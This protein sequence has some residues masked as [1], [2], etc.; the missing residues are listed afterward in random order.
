[1]YLPL[2]FSPFDFHKRRR[3][4]LHFAFHDSNAGWRE[5][6]SRS[7]S[8]VVPKQVQQIINPILHRA[9]VVT[10]ADLGFQDP[11]HEHFKC[12][13][14]V[15]KVGCGKFGP[16]FTYLVTYPL[17]HATDLWPF[18]LSLFCAIWVLRHIILITS[19][20]LHVIVMP[21]FFQALDKTKTVTSL[22]HRVSPFNCCLNVL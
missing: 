9:S 17:W 16:V 4:S 2:C 1:M 15:A 5:H 20:V 13:A 7:P 22:F 10:M 14:A 18:S 3:G 21:T 12:R 19:H 11:V 8:L 6:A